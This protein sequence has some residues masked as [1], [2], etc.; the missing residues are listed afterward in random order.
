MVWATEDKLMA[1]EHDPRL[2]ELSPRGRQVE[3]GDSSTLVPEDRPERLAEVLTEFRAEAGNV[4][5]ATL[6]VRS[7]INLST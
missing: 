5:Y 1:R 6:R 4:T 3:V 7:E 2:A